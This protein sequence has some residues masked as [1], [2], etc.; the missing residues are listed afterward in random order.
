MKKFLRLDLHA[1]EKEIPADVDAVI[2]AHAAI[3]AVSFRKKK[4]LQR[5]LFPAASIGAAA[6]ATLIV[7]LTPETAPQPSMQGIPAARVAATVPASRPVSVQPQAAA[8]AQ[9]AAAA[10][11]TA[12]VQASEMLALA[13]TTALEQECYNLTVMTDESFGSDEMFI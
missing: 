8:A 4:R 3:K 2:L 11:V 1:P 6:A 10:T 5:I 7:C 9:P 12:A 13:D